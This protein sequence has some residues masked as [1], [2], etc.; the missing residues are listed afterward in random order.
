MPWSD[1]RRQV[2]RRHYREVCPISE[3]ILRIVGK[4]VCCLSRLDILEDAGVSQLCVGTKA[5][6]EGAVHDMNELFE[7]GKS[8]R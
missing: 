6:A 7:V 1:V 4:V 5:G 2:P 8:D 3:A